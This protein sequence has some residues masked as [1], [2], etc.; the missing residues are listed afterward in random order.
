MTT[1]EQAPLP[2]FLLIQRVALS[3]QPLIRAAIAAVLALMCTAVLIALAGKDPI[4]A[5]R[6]LFSGAFGS[7]DRVAFALHKAT[8]YML[9]GI[10][11]ALCFR[12]KI[13]NIGGEGQIAIGGLAATWAALALPA[14]DPVTAIALALLA[15]SAGGALWAGVA[16][17]IHLSRRVHE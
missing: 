16:T 10:G 13:I 2:S 17:I 3:H 11:I 7:F 5:Y 15:A 6:A 8:P 9:A 1:A 12:A 4:L 14:A